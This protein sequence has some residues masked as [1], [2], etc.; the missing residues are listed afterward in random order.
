M[1]SSGPA[2]KVLKRLFNVQPEESTSALL[3]FVYFFLITASGYIILTVKI[4]LLLFSL[5]AERLPYAYLLTAVMIGFVVSL[6]SRLMQ[7]MK[8][9]KYVMLTTLFFIVNLFLF[10]IL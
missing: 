3:L 10:W 5:S 9:E 4:S 7:A 8:R 6:N 2:Q 1:N